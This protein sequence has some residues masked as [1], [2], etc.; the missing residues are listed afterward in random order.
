[1]IRCLVTGANGQLGSEMR[2]LSEIAANE[3]LFTDIDELDITSKEATKEY[4]LEHRPNVIVN[5]AAY[6]KVDAAEDDT[7]VAYSVNASAAENLALA[8]KEV[9]AT[10]IHIS[11]D[12]VFDGE[13]NTPYT[14]EC[15]PCPKS[16]YG[17]SKLDGEKKVEESGCNY[18]IIRTS[19]LYSE[20]GS[21]F[22]KTIIRLGAQ[23]PSIK[24]VFDQVGTPTYA[25]DLAMAIFSI[26][27]TQQLD[28]KSGTYHFSNEGVCSWYDFAVEIIRAVGIAE[29]RV[30]PCHSN[31]FPTRAQRPKYSVLDKSKIKEVFGIDIPHWRESLNYCIERLKRQYQ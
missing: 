25:G 31:E 26:I 16:V 14:E 27:E 20:Y 1:M 21:N 30:L 5:C 19:W 23:N 3:Y 6:T 22:L 11:T 2:R 7:A 12:Y 13:S 18:L 28:G 8:A 17:K 15:L 4:I 24:V 10:L 9:G 29:C